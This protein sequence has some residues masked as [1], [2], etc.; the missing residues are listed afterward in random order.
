MTCWVT[1]ANFARQQQVQPSTVSRWLRVPDG[2]LVDA[3]DARGDK[4][5]T[6]HPSVK[7][8]LESQDRKADRRTIASRRSLEEDEDDFESGTQTA[9]ASPSFADAEIMQHLTV[10]EIATRFGGLPMFTEYV[11]TYNV[12]QDARKKELGNLKTDG[13]L[14]SRDLVRAA[15][16]THVDR[17]HRRLITDF[18]ES[19][20]RLI[21]AHC[22]AGDALEVAKLTVRDRIGKVLGESIEHAVK[23]FTELTQ[24]GIAS[25]DPDSETL[26]SGSIVEQEPS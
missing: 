24:D 11:K 6:D 19:I 4:I 12:L 1:K 7:R 23:G 10:A 22:N 2:P 3:L 25:D 17:L 16:L 14:V 8:F 20:T 26:E 5:D 13:T 15:V 21:Y 9:G 18:A